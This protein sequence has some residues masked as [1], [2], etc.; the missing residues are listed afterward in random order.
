MTQLLQSYL[1]AYLFWLGIA[2]G[3]FAFLAIHGLTGGR[4]GDAVRAPLLAAV[5]TI[6]LFAV[7]FL[8]LLIGAKLLFPW[9]T[10]DAGDRAAYLNVPFLAIRAAIY[11]ACWI[12]LALATLRRRAV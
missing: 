4:W 1:F 11:F 7:L 10:H 3:S 2:L 9:T 12:A 8:P 6:P 5:G